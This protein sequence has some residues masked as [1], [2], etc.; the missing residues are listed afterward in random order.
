MWGPLRVLPCMQAPPSA[1]RARDSRSSNSRTANSGAATFWFTSGVVSPRTSTD[2]PCRCR[3]RVAAERRGGAGWASL[4]RGARGTLNASERVGGVRGFGPC[5]LESELSLSLRAETPATP[6][7]VRSRRD[8]R[9]IN[10]SATR[11]A[12]ALHHQGHHMSSSL[13]S[14]ATQSAARRSSSSCLRV[15]A[16]PF[17]SRSRQAAQT[18]QASPAGRRRIRARAA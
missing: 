2:S 17:A 4:L 16:P 15:W 1:L 14:Q 3:V 6:Q 7:K 11:S 5:S 12:A 10:L 8:H 9:G 13:S 18:R